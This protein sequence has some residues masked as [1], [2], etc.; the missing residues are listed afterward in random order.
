MTVGVLP[1]LLRS[2]LE[3][4]LT[5]TKESKKGKDNKKVQLWVVEPSL[6]GVIQ[7]ELSVNVVKGEH[8]KCSVSYTRMG[9]LSDLFSCLMRMWSI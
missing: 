4:N 8:G 2:F 6:A 5:K 7:K 3:M 1:D 9:A